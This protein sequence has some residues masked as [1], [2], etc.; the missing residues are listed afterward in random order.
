[1]F[2]RVTLGPTDRWGDESRGEER[3][4]G[5]RLHGAILFL[6]CV[7]STFVRVWVCMCVCVQMYV[8]TAV[9]LHEMYASIEKEIK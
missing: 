1:M 8:H 9:C 2:P 6:V 3:L 7:C 5:S 4:G